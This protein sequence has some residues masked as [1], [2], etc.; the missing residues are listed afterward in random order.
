MR[1]GVIWALVGVNLTLLVLIVGSKLHL[2]QA[3]AQSLGLAGNYL[4]VSGGVLGT[5]SDAVYVVDLGNREL[6]ALHME[7]SSK[8]IEVRGRRDLA[9]DLGAPSSGD[10]SRR[11]RRR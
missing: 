2:P 1:K 6:L 10:T 3:V 8:M 11:S 7:R 5:T 4:M 9:R